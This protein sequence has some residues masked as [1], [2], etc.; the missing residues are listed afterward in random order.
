MLFASR[1]SYL[2][3]HFNDSFASPHYMVLIITISLGK[4]GGFVLRASSITLFIFVKTQ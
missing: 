3:N 2:K 4:V 1:K